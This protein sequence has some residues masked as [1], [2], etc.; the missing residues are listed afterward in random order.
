MSRRDEVNS[1]LDTMQFETDFP[2]IP[3]ELVHIVC[4]T[5]T[6]YRKKEYYRAEPGYWRA[7][8][9]KDKEFW[10]AL[11]KFQYE[12]DPADYEEV[13][14]R[15]SASY[16]IMQVMYD[17]AVD[18]Y[19]KE[20]GTDLR[21]VADGFIAS[22]SFKTE[23]FEDLDLPEDLNDDEIGLWYGIKEL[24]EKI[25]SVYTGTIKKYFDRG[26]KVPNLEDIVK[27]SEDA[28]IY[29]C[30]RELP[31]IEFYKMCISAY[32]SG[33][34]TISRLVGLAKTNNIPAT[35]ENLKGFIGDIK[36][37]E[38]VT[39]MT[40]HIARAFKDVTPEMLKLAK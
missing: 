25:N 6:S 23:L 8:M 4:N 22:G 32:Q 9:V 40:N 26:R 28:K 13:S 18:N 35:W 3:R 21:E 17:I 33:P 15:Y 2:L 14:K 29:L 12:K 10:R 7:Y 31:L 20:K 39:Q 37:D 1:L 16:G 5:E 27:E 34:G 36:S 19:L 38:I 30:S 24:E 11:Y